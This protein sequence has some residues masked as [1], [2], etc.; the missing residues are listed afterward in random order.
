MVEKNT[1]SPRQERTSHKGVIATAVISSVFSRAEVQVNFQDC[2]GCALQD[3][4]Y[5]FLYGETRNRSE[6]APSLH[7]RA[8]GQQRN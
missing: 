4:E 6:P 8:D 5:V 1:N 7:R 3:E 2:A